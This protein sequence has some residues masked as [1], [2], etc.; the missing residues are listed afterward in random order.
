MV[1]FKSMYVKLK[2]NIH[3]LDT[4]ITL[5]T[6]KVLISFLTCLFGK[7]HAQQIK[8]NGIF[9]IHEKFGVRNTW[10]FYETSISVF[11]FLPDLALT[12]VNI[13]LECRH[14]EKMSMDYSYMRSK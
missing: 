4:D 2:E 8:I 11:G 14:G 13:Q 3:I 7:F 10:P 12:F 5:Y 9:G 6:S 1:W